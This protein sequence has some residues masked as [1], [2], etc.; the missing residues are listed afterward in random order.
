MASGSGATGE[1]RCPRLAR[2]DRTRSASVVVAR[3]EGLVSLASPA[4]VDLASVDLVALEDAVDAAGLVV[5]EALV[6]ASRAALAEVV[7]SKPL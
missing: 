1:T 5:A 4:S 2:R 7:S 6:V 3:P